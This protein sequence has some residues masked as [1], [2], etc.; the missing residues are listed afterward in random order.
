VVLAEYHQV[1]AAAAWVVQ[2]AMA[3][4]AAWAAPVVQ[5]GLAGLAVAAAKVEHEEPSPFDSVFVVRRSGVAGG[6]HLQSPARASW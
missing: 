6:L 2:Q 5:A 1:V 3:E 4:L